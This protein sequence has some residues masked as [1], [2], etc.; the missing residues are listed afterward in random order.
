MKWYKSF[1]LNRVNLDLVATEDRKPV[2]RVVYI[3]VEW[4]EPFI[5]KYDS[6]AE[7]EAVFK[8]ILDNEIGVPMSECAYDYNPENYPSQIVL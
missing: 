1:S 3:D 5:G 4:N 2:Y 7:A 6:F 8:F